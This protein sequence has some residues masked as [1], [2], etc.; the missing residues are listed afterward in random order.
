MARHA[1]SNRV[2]AGGGKL[3]DGAIRLLGKDKG[4]RSRPER[5]GQ[6]FG[7]VVKARESMRCGSIRHMRNQRI[8]R[9]AALG[10][11]E[12]RYRFAVS[13]IRAEAINRLGGKSD[14]T[15]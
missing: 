5:A 11:V 9:W 4:E 10:V 14:E 1:H 3:G 15:P 13:R 8:E 6:P 2:D 12:A 7:R